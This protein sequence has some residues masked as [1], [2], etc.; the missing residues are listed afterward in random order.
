MTVLLI[1]AYVSFLFFFP[2]KWRTAGQS[3]KKGGVRQIADWSKVVRALVGGPQA[4]TLLCSCLSS[5]S[6]L[7]VHLWKHAHKTLIEQCMLGSGM[8]DDKFIY[9]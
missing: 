7:T 9:G 6:S 1:V 3:H 2:G 5:S 4:A 8:I